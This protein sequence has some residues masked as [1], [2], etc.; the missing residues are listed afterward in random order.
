MCTYIYIYTHITAAR[1]NDNTIP[2]AQS[3]TTWYQL[4]VSEL[5]VVLVVVA[6]AAAAALT[7]FDTVAVVATV[8]VVVA[9]L[10]CWCSCQFGI[11]VVG[12][13]VVI[14]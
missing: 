12:A 7:F 5:V 4:I 14:I 8:A 11:A 1:N 10:E 13:T 9:V 3:P 6:V 2:I